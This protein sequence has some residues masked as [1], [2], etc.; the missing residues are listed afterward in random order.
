MQAHSS[1]R[2][3]L[4]LAALLLAMVI[5]AIE[6]T[7]VAT[8]MPSIAAQ[9]G[10]FSLYTW[11]F[12]AYLLTQ[13]ATI[14]MFGKL[15]DLY[16]RK[17]VLIFG[18][19]VF[20][21]GS[22]LCGFAASMPWLI[23]FRF[24]QG[25]GAGALQP[26]TMTLAADLYPLRERAKVQV[27]FSAVWGCA[28]VVGPLAG[29]L[30]VQYGNWPWVFWLTVPVAPIAIFLV[31]RYLHESVEKR[32]RSIDY[33]GAA[34]FFLGLS[35][36]MLA[37]TQGGNWSVGALA[38]IL[39]VAAL[40]L[41]LF[42]LQEGRAPEPMMH[43]ELWRDPLIARANGAT[44]T[45]GITL[46]G[47][48][49]FLP[50]YVQAVLGGSAL[51]AGFTLSAM[52]L[53]WPLAAFFSARLLVVHGNQF[54]GRIGAVS[55]AGGALIM[56]LIGGRAAPAAALGAFFVGAG[57]GFLN[58]TFVVSIQASVGWERRGIATA[59]NVL[60][61]ILGTA[62]GAAFLG[63]LL[64]LTLQRYIAERG[65]EDEISPDRVRELLAGAGHTGLPAEALAVLHEGLARGLSWVFWLTAAMALLTAFL[66]WRVPRLRYPQIEK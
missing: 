53:G 36:L 51:L 13:A 42:V 15:A 23:A 16:G 29:G 39:A 43:L 35:A 33:V 37:L 49:A 48:I 20:I 30:I 3:P 32:D 10:D 64:N 21:I 61:R 9:L 7:I 41:G 25:A 54:T 47:L 19:V 11:V 40:L 45:A 6:G 17:P 4:V 18:I 27:Y 60:M 26:T 58:N 34:L 62:L 2:R 52:T 63:G 66:A 24:L 22:V 38:G 46:I 55:M 14:P 65:L 56:A 57:M 8:A 28:S 50:T 44:L 1:T 59:S 31:S 5:A 12:S